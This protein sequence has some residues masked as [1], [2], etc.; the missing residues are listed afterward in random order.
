LIVAAVDRLQERV[1][2]DRY[3][4]GIGGFERVVLADGSVIELNTNTEIRVSFSTK[5]REV[6]LVTGE[7]SFNV[8][9]DA[10][11]PFVVV[12]GDAAVR[13]LGTQFNVR[14][15]GE[16]VDVIVTEGR[17]AVGQIDVATI[18]APAFSGSSRA[19]VVGAGQAAR[20]TRGSAYVRRES[21]QDAAREL[22][23]QDGML[24]F[25]SAP[26][27]EVVAEF[28]RYNR[29][30]LVI[31]D[32]AIAGREIGGYFKSRNLDIF[33]KILHSSFGVDAE[34]AGDRIVLRQGGAGS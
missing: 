18:S 15:Q 20:V 17:V 25:N 13:S 10:G 22:A 23:W 4:T 12:A 31:A 2:E 24:M 8:T 5:R 1:Q 11:R 27:S 21:P 16:V 3:H 14:Q 28:N 6:S 34:V 7:A 33:V 30:Q 29:R 32:P 26:L 9:H 19:P